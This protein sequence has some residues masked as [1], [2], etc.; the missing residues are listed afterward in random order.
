M[1]LSKQLL[2]LIS[3]LF[4]MIFSLNFVLSV[5]NI[6]SYL[7]GESQV[8]AQDTATSLGL[9]L[10]PHMSDEKDPVLETM[11]S[12]IFDRGYYKQIKLLNV[13][14]EPLVTLSNEKA[15]D[16]VPAWFISQLP[17]QAAVAESE[18]SSGWNISGIVLVEINPNYAYL[19]LYEQVKRSF[20][21]SLLT[22]ALSVFLLLVVLQITLSSLKRIGKMAE[23]ISQGSFDVIERLPWTLEVR[24][25]ATSMNVMSKKLE[26][27]IAN[28]NTRLESIGKKLQLDDLT[29]LSKRTGFDM[30]TKELLTSH[31]ETY[32]MMIKIDAL[33]SLVKE[34]GSD[35]IDQF[36]KDFA[37][38]LSTVSE[39][40]DHQNVKAYRFF[41]S[42]FVIL[43]QGLSAEQV[44]GL[45]TSLSVAFGELGKKYQKTDIAHIGVA[46]FDPFSSKN[47]ILLAANEAYEQAQ[48][49]GANS[50]YL[51]QGED[52]AKDM[53]EWKELV[54]DTIDRNNYKVSYL[55]AVE[56]MQ[57]GKVMMEEAFSEAFDKSGQPVSIATF[58]SIAEKFVKIVDLDEGVITRTVEHIKANKTPHLVAI[59][60][61][62]RTVKNSDFRAR[63][64]GLIANNKAVAKHIVFS[65]S[66]YA[67][68]KEINVY[69]EFISFAH[70]LNMKVIIKRFETQSMAPDLIKELRP[71]F[72]RLARDI[73]N[74]ISRDE[75]KKEFTRTMIEVCELL[76]I[77]VLAENVKSETDFNCLKDIGVTGASH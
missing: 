24:R 57:T 47:T 28:L 39:E 55:G 35:A 32:V 40:K 19:K 67:V 61:S 3:A 1:S 50:Y 7:E 52:R 48:L 10:S 30:D 77:Q 49:I 68:A 15:I 11:I 20:Y 36:L 58:V 31:V 23:T 45:A 34:L 9:S 53:A 14:G 62:S 41:G 73:G 54:F 44:E 22:F 69:K 2:L 43:T 42:E 16:G 13:E 71:D 33:S 38:I 46:V 56:N 5:E 59:N 63:L 4:L 18:I 60:L 64:G 72:V 70:S 65:L 25:V 37:D 12:A 8:H 6:R 21:Y 29:G 26:R 17:M 75:H 76:D 27:V 74:G 66:A 51:R